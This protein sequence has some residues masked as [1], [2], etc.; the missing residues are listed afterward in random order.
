MPVLP[1]ADRAERE[2]CYVV[3]ALFPIVGF[4]IVTREQGRQGD[5]D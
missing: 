2:R 5:G 3:L 4:E 1:V